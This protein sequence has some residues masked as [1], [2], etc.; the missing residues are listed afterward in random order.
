MD[1][2]VVVFYYF[3]CSYFAISFWLLYFDSFMKVYTD[4]YFCG[5]ILII[6]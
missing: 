2:W 1:V 3:A 4:V 5:H 6:G